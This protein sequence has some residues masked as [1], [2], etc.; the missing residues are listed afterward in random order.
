MGNEISSQT[1][2]ER[3]ENR[4]DLTLD[5]NSS[6]AQFSQ[7]HQHHHDAPAQREGHHHLDNMLDGAAFNPTPAAQSLQPVVIDPSTQDQMNWTQDNTHIMLP[8]TKLRDLHDEV[9]QLRMQLGEYEIENA[10][11]KAS[12]VKF[13]ERAEAAQKQQFEEKQSHHRR[14][15]KLQA[16]IEK[17]NGQ[18]RGLRAQVASYQAEKSGNKIIAN[19]GKVSDDEI[20][21]SWKTMAYNIESLVASILTGSPCL[22]DL[23]HQHKGKK[24]SCAVCL[25]N[26]KQVFFLQND[27]MRPSIVESIV[28][29]AIDRQVLSHNG[30]HSGRIWAGIQGQLFSSLFNKLLVAPEMNDS[31]SQILRWKA[32]S[33]AMIDKAFGVDKNELDDTVY[34]EHL[35]LLRF[36]PSD[37][38]DARTKRKSLYKELREIFKEAVMIHRMLMQSRAHFYLDHVD[39]VTED[40]V[41]YNPEYHEAEVWD[42]EL[43]EKSIVL[44]GIAPSLVKIGNADGGNYDKSN[45]LV[46]ASVICD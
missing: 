46:K 3:E 38:P 9:F 35:G 29:D 30:R 44:L 1:N 43:S 21:A 10:S 18:N 13:Q 4:A 28:W 23:R 36:I 20:R 41:H 24:R 17:L 27:D 12:I 34:E 7:D 42:K 31:P 19:S 16:H 5:M 8:G 37:C 22:D 26:A 45:R 33:A 15:P 39:T 25:M 6:E 2:G 40:V 32:D 14:F 11:L